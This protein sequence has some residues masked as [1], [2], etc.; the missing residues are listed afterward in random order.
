MTDISALAEAAEARSEQMRQ[1]TDRPRERRLSEA[2]ATARAPLPAP[3]SV[4]STSTAAGFVHFVGLASAYERAYEMWDA[5]GPYTEVVTAGAGAKSLARD[6]LDVT[7]N[8]G[9]DQMRRIAST[10]AGTLKLTESD[11]GLEVDAQLNPADSD[12]D[13]AKRKIE[14]GLYTEMSFAFRIVRGA[15]SPDYSEY[16]INEY[17]IHRGDVAIVGYGANPHTSAQL[18]KSG[19]Q[20]IEEHRTRRLF[21]V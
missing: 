7:L 16:R 1:R 19:V 14:D 3:L 4:R 8:L 13:Y 11:A 21:Y 5:Y 18:R 15:W 20:L 2:G 9:H 6:D 17:D 10:L 12:V